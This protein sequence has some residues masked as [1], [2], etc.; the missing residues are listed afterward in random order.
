[1]LSLLKIPWWINLSYHLAFGSLKN[2]P[3]CSQHKSWWLT[4]QRLDILSQVRGK[5]DTSKPGA[6]EW[7]NELHAHRCEKSIEFGEKDEKT[8]GSVAH[9]NMVSIRIWNHNSDPKFCAEQ[10]AV[11]HTDHFNPAVQH[12]SP[13]RWPHM[14]YQTG[15]LPPVSFKP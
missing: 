5:T 11:K 12:F 10:V 8:W 1:M 4:R 7:M 2:W 13:S 14:G 15:T 3:V 6:S 9:W